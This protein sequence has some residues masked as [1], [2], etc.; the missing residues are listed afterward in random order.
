MKVSLGKLRRIIR[1]EITETPTEEEPQVEKIVERIKGIMDRA[2]LTGERGLFRLIDNKDEFE[3][4]IR[5]IFDQSGFPNEKLGSIASSV[6]RD[7]M[8][9]PEAAATMS[10]FNI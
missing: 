5:Y 8:K 3:D 2:N 1:E 6:A 7:F 9:D 10:K 4:L